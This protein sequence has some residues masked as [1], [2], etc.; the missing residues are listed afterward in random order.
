MYASQCWNTASLYS[1]CFSRKELFI[2]NCYGSKAYQKS[3]SISGK[4]K[5]AKV[6]Q[7]HSRWAL[8]HQP[9]RHFSR[10]C[11]CSI[12]NLHMESST[13]SVSPNPWSRRVWIT[14]SASGPMSQES[15]TTILW[16]IHC[17]HSQIEK[18]DTTLTLTTRMGFEI[19][20][21][22]KIWFIWYQL[23]KYGNIIDISC[24]GKYTAMPL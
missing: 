13:K 19:I 12:Y 15:Y 22:L 9:L 1:M 2:A 21:P 18:M 23:Q 8:C 7:N 16:T 6:R 4:L 10:M 17:K 11:C 20:Y 3:V 14:W 5:H 24:L